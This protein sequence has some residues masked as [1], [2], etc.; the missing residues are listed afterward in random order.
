MEEERGKK[1]RKRRG[2]RGEEGG[3]GDRETIQ[4]KLRNNRKYK[5]EPEVGHREGNGDRGR[6]EEMRL[7]LLIHQKLL[8]LSTQPPPPIPKSN[9]RVY[10][11]HF[12]L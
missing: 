4:E 10:A 11:C 3:G 6:K 8:P 2:G 1:R 12:I 7:V 5:K 9:P